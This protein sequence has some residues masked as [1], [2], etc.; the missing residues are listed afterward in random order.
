MY[1]SLR[2]ALNAIDWGRFRS[3]LEEVSKPGIDRGKLVG[4]VRKY[5]DAKGIE[6]DWEAIDKA[7][8]E[9]LV[10][11]IAM[12]CPFDPP[13]KQALLE[14]GD[15]SGRSELLTTIVQLAALDQGDG[16]QQ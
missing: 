11:S 12:L 3:D 13:E 5:F 9:Y 15:L 8:D 6:A 4:A 1:S 7:G 10:T 16:A 2:S 14:A